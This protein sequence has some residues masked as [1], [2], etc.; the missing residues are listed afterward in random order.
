M[1]LPNCKKGGSFLFAMFLPTHEGD[2]GINQ[3]EH[4]SC[5]KRARAASRRGLL[6]D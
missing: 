4:L 6:L 3:S 1:R 2:F 5:L